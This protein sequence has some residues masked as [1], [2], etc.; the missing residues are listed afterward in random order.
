MHSKAEVIKRTKSFVKEKM[1]ADASGHDWFHVERV[2]KLATYISKKEKNV[3]IFIVQLAALLH[4]IGDWKF[5]NGDSTIG[6]KTAH[7]VLKHL[8]V[9]EGI[10]KDVCYI[11]EHISYKAGSNSRKM[12]NI[13]GMIVQDADRLDALGAIGIARAFAYGGYKQ[14][15]IHNPRITKK[16]GVTPQVY[17]TKKGT[18]I[19]HFY[20]KLL[21]LQDTMHT[22][23]AKRIA[24]KRHDF[25]LHFLDTFYQEWNS[26]FQE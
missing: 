20:E 1:K 21:L 11:V 12:K 19:N 14:Q 2:L 15:E 23:T 22:K 13:E 10:I 7:E 5:N 3:D 16:I 9:P 6:S 18:T 24:Q 4:D 26:T 8:S 17:L 25:M